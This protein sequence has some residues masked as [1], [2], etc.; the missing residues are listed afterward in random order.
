[1][2]SAVRGVVAELFG[3]E[4]LPHPA[5]VTIVAALSTTFSASRLVYSP[6]SPIGARTPRD[7]T[8]S[9][10]AARIGSQATIREARGDARGSGA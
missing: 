3:A 1:M 2:V 7:L 4:P 8:G 9:W 6:P 10:R 5:D